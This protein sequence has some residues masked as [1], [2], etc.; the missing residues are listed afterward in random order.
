[1]SLFY[2]QRESSQALDPDASLHAYG[3]SA[4]PKGVQIIK[5]KVGITTLTSITL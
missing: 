3:I 4:I 1:M 5:V 2:L